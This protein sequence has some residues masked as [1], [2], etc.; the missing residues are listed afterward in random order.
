[1]NWIEIFRTG[2]HT[3]SAGRTRSF[4]A[5][6]L[7]HMVTTLDPGRH[8][9][10]LVLGHPKDDAP[11]Y[12]WVAALKRQGETLLAAF[13]DVPGPVR[14][15]VEKG[16]YKKRSISLYPDGRLRHVGLLGAAVPAVQ[17]LADIAA[18]AADGESYQEF[19]DN[20]QTE[21]TMDPKEM[22]ARMQA[23]LAENALLKAKAEGAD[24]GKIAE[25]EAKVQTL[26]EGKKKAEAAQAATESAFAEMRAA[27]ARKELE[28]RV[29]ALVA[30]G[31]LLPKDKAA[32]MAFAEGL[33]EGGELEFSEGGGKKPVQ[34]HFFDFLASQPGHGL[35]QE[36]AAPGTGGAG[37]AGG[38]AIPYNDI[39]NKV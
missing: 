38:T 16:R 35:M 18:F 36:F 3:D 33:A 13:K 21:A 12:G 8:E 17:G 11:A 4:T 9:P 23:L 19:E 29:D 1:M 26:A 5:A 30:T 24:A 39:M 15:A 37:S 25:L 2:T 34:A 27:T 14:A 28:G 32:V 10:P 6:H 31:K 7:D 20:P 22:E